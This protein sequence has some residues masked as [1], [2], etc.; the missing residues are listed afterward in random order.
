[1]EAILNCFGLIF[2]SEMSIDSDQIN[3]L[4]YR[5]LQESGAPAIPLAE[6]F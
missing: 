3:Y 1:M 6:I 2:E 4:V 5:Y